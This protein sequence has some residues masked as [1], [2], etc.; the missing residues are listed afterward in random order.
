[1]SLSITEPILYA[2]VELT[3]HVITHFL[4]A[5]TPNS[6]N[7]YTWLP[8]VQAPLKSVGIKG[9]QIVF[10][11]AQ[12]SSVQSTFVDVTD[13]LDLLMPAKISL[14]CLH[15]TQ[16]NA[17]SQNIFGTLENSISVYII[18][19]TSHDFFFQHYDVFHEVAAI[20]S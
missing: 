10:D 4:P 2:L 8:L 5:P 18:D 3:V 15:D 9:I 1:M 7:K 20:L 19:V 12:C 16:L 11:E 6:I 13:I 14:Q 17:Q